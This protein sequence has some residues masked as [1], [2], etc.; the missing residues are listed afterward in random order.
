MQA[1]QLYGDARKT[2]PANEWLKKVAEEVQS[3]SLEELRE[4]IQ[5][6]FQATN[7]E[8]LMPSSLMSMH[9]NQQKNCHPVQIVHP[10]AIIECTMPLPIQQPPRLSPACFAKIKAHQNSLL[11]SYCTAAEWTREEQ[12]VLEEG[13]KRCAESASP[14][15]LMQPGRGGG[16]QPGRRG[17]TWEGGSNL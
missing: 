8:M 13:L 4:H 2:M 14:I 5:E 15:L 3:R 7:S 17:A 10:N 1:L 16:E 12:I 11:G 9:E 6:Y